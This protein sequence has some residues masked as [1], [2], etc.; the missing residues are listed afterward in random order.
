MIYLS[1]GQYKTSHFA[2]T[3]AFMAIGMMI[4]G[5][6]SG[7]IQEWLGYQHFFIWVMI[8]TLPSF[9]VIKFIHLDPEFGKKKE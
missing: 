3:T 5:M 1:E 4:P 8:A 9:I 7:Y 2:I 6:V